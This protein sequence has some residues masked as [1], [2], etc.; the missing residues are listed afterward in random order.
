MPTTTELATRA[1]K[2]AGVLDPAES[3]TAQEATDVI[4]VMQ[5]VYDSMK[6]RGHIQWTLTDIPARYQDPFI[7]IVA[8]RIAADFGVLSDTLVA[9]GRSGEREIYALNERRIDGRGTPV[10]DF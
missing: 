5:S 10:V 1:L 8:M 6:E 9:L 3:P 7:N 4:A 2:R